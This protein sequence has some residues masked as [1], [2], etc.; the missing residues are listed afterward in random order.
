MN[1]KDVGHGLFD[2]VEYSATKPRSL[3]NGREGIVQEH[4]TRGFPGHICAPA[5]HGDTD[6]CRFQGRGI[7]DAV[8]GHGHYISVG[9]HCH[10][11]S[12]FLLRHH[13]G[14]YV[15]VLYALLKIRIG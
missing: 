13:S 11:Q 12:Q 6:V 2:I 15:C 9:L 5:A 4:E 14:K 7:I 1:G 8:A 10:D 3:H